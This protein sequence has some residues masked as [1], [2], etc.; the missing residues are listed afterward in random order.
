MEKLTVAEIMKMFDNDFNMSV[1]TVESMLYNA[2]ANKEQI[3]RLL[4]RA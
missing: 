4:G 3:D 2:G 1:K